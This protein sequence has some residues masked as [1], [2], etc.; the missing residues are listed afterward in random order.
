MMGDALD[1]V[2]LLKRVLLFFAVDDEGFFVVPAGIWRLVAQR[3]LIAE[4]AFLSADRAHRSHHLIAGSQKA[5]Q[6]C[7]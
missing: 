4:Q 5:R 7:C 1:L 2:R 3:T 6:V